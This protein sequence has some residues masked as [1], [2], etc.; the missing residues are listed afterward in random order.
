MFNIRILLNT[1]DRPAIKI[2][3]KDWIFPGGEL[4]IKILDQ[5]LRLK[6]S[7]YDYITIDARVQ[8]T[9]DLFAIA[10]VQNAIKELTDR[11]INLYIPYIPYARQDRICDN[12]ESFSVKVLANYL[13]SLKFDTVT[14]VDPHS[15]VTPALIDNVKVITQLDLIHNN[16][17]LK[18]RILEL[19][20]I[21]VSPD[22]GANK[23]TAKI[24]GYFGHR[25]FVRADKLR[26]LTNGNI[27]ETIVYKDD[28]N[29]QN[30]A[31]FD[32]IC[33]KGGTFIALAK[34]LK[35]K[36]A[37]KILLFV[38]HGLFSGDMNILYNSGINEIWCTNSYKNDLDS[39]INV[40]KI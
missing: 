38:T 3:T 10:L 24:A 26:D 1:V 28:F 39:R 32:D 22:A 5:N 23:K 13:N 12:G 14:I 37:G 36:N 34:V 2:E 20:P 8:N 21:L 16:A 30:V 17:Q 4:G 6:H 11:R 27:L 15:D 25:E 29:G 18:N 19:K 7:N 33:E 31:I 35:Q 40:I 9:N